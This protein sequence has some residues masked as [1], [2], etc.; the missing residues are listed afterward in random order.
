MS[1]ITV[2][3][4]NTLEKSP[5]VMPLISSS[6]TEAGDTYTNTNMTDKMQ[7]SIF[8]IQVPLIMINN[9]IVDFDAIY[10]FNLKSK[11][12]LPELVMTVED[13]YE[14]INNID[15][16]GC[17]N[18]V[19]VQILPKFEDAYKKVNL[20]FFISSM[21]VNGKL[22]RL[23]CSYKSPALMASQ[24]KTF[25]ECDTYD[26]FKSA[27]QQT[28]LGFATNIT[29]CD[30]FRYAYCDNK[31]LFELLN[32]EINYANATEHIMDWWVDLWDN[33]NL[34]DVKDRYESVD[35][36]EDI[37]I[38]VTGQ[39]CEITNEGV[40][41]PEQMPA[42]ISNFPGIG[43]SELF[44]KKYVINTKS[45]INMSAGTDKVFGVYEDVKLEYSDTLVQDGDIR[46]DIFIKYDYLGESYGEYNYMLAKKLRA[47]FLNKMNS[48]T[49]MVTLQTPLLALMR[50]HKVN[51]IRYVNDD[52]VENK[53]RVLEEAGLIDRNI[54]SNIPLS[55]YDAMQNYGSGRFTLDR[56]ASG[57]YLITG[58]ELIYNNREWDY[59]LTLT[60]PASTKAN[61]IKNE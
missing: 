20:T 6:V 15:K 14:I 60:K 50:G 26:I 11:G 61:I 34:V 38:W 23:T 49:I 18:E 24:Y 22:L 57:Q 40:I 58:I 48:E 31:S 27:A 13:R 12:C 2:E 37:K 46:K 41:T 45:G 33:I 47:S 3:F 19:R 36:D 39:S 59:V 54:E 7:T 53:M 9:T 52:A 4:D 17:D 30:D 51:F 10:Y 29:E 32:D 43:A 56:T 55:Q 42:V 25:G 35:S 28:Q 44:V 8:G 1:V 21:Q 5:I 16:P